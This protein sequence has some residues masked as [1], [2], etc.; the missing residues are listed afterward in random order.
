MSDGDRLSNHGRIILADTV[1][2]QCSLKFYAMQLLNQLLSLVLGL[3]GGLLGS[4]PG[5]PL[6]L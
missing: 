3:L 1:I 6:G 4:L 5:L 2:L